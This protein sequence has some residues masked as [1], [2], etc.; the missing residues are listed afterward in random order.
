MGADVFVLTQ[1][2]LNRD[3][4]VLSRAP[5][6]EQDAIPSACGGQRL[7]PGMEW[8]TQHRAAVCEDTFMAVGIGKL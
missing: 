4:S 2:P 5:L 1:S 7:L 3:K 8:S 6:T